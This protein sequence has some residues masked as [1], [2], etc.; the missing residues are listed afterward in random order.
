MTS[1]TEQRTGKDRRHD[2]IHIETARVPLKIV[3]TV[4]A[5]V[6]GILMTYYASVSA[7]GARVAVLESQ[8][9]TT[10]RSLDRIEGKV[11][12]LIDLRIREQ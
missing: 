6:A 4:V 1:V 9:E 2:D 10:K 3:V 7:L 11:D 12:R 5:F 8:Q